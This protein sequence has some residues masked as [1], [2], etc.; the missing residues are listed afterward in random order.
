MSRTLPLYLKRKIVN[1]NLL[2]LYVLLS[3]ATAVYIC[4]LHYTGISEW[5]VF[6]GKNIPVKS[7]D[8][9]NDYI[10]AVIWAWLLSFLILC[11]PMGQRSWRKILLLLWYVKIGVVLF[12][13]LLYEYKYAI[14]DMYTYFYN[15]QWLDS[16]NLGTVRGTELILSLVALHHEVFPIS[17]HGLKVTF[18]FAGFLGCY[19]FYRSA[20]VFLSAENIRLLLLFMLMPSLLFWTAFPG[21]DSLMVL[22]LS[23]Y[24]YGVINW[25][26]G[27]KLLFL[28]ITLTGIV[29][30][31]RI[32]PWFEMILIIPFL[33]VLFCDLLGSIGALF[34]R[35]AYKYTVLTIIVCSVFLITAIIIHQS[36]LFDIE[37]IIRTANAM[38]IGMSRGGSMNMWEKPFETFSD[39][40]AFVPFGAFASLFRP[41]PFEVMHPFGILSGIENLILLA[42]FIYSLFNIKLRALKNPIFQWV[43]ILIL[44]WLAVYTFI[45]YF[46]FGTAVRY[47]TQILPFLFFFMIIIAQ[48][49]SVES[50]SF[51]AWYHHLY[52]VIMGKSTEKYSGVGQLEE[53]LPRHGVNQYE[54]TLDAEI[55]RGIAGVKAATKSM[56]EKLPFIKQIKDFCAEQARKIPMPHSRIKADVPV[57]QRN[58]R[59]SGTGLEAGEGAHNLYHL[60]YHVIWVTKYR[61]HI[62][63][64]PLTN[65]LQKVL[66]KSLKKTRGINIESLDFADDYVYMVII[67]PP[68][69]SIAKIMARLKRRTSRRAKKTF[70]SLNKTCRK[71]EDIWSPGY[72]INSTG[73]NRNTLQNYLEYQAQ[74]D[75]SSGV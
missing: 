64:P 11:F 21:K 61:Q 72:F 24:A 4:L 19:L 41:L 16:I 1:I 36:G 62:L 31:V 13:G 30:C 40:L 37:K 53:S 67:I 52:N 42:V 70:S 55:E 74:K 26:K 14:L 27:Y 15:A 60:K 54:D 33:G 10:I 59:I 68:E 56:G 65:H 29:L 18:A 20:V 63:K 58:Q 44:C 45:S 8:L 75:L 69:Y 50:L 5:V 71:D 23:L 17:F 9:K 32:R 28:L 6:L 34:R 3:L 57:Y 51:F 12:A 43:C 66:L 73:I 2:T 39:L 35:P 46:N 38:R 48:Y 47:K 25:L 49:R 22:F 7:H